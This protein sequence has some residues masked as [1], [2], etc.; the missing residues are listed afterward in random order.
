M[1]TDP[2]AGLAL[3][4][5]IDVVLNH[6]LGIMERRGDAMN[7]LALE[8]AFLL[9]IIK[10]DTNLF[11]NSTFQAIILQLLLKGLKQRED[12]MSLSAFKMMKDPRRP[13]CKMGLDEMSLDFVRF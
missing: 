2:H 10:F 12:W 4:A 13:S 11:T 5:A 1:I 8:Y 7:E 3:I 9:H 6:G